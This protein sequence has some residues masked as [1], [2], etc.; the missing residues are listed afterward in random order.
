MKNGLVLLAV[1]VSL[2]SFVGMMRIKTDVQQLARERQRLAS[3]QLELREAKRVLEAE[4]AMLA[5]PMR[6]AELAKSRGFK[7]L[8]VARLTTLVPTLPAAPSPTLA[9][10]ATP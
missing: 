3:E 6:L 7:E 10:G 4:Y 1:T 2:A 8:T 5:N 9:A